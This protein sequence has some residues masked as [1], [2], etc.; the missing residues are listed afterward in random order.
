M[1]VEGAPL[2]KKILTNLVYMPL[3]TWGL[4]FTHCRWRGWKRKWKSVKVFNKDVKSQSDA[5]LQE[6]SNEI[7]YTLRNML[8]TKRNHNFHTVFQSYNCVR[9]KLRKCFMYPVQ[10]VENN[11]DWSCIDCFHSILLSGLTYNSISNQS[12]AV[13]DLV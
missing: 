12:P 13:H 3:N 11:I 8:N 7:C 10:Y 2:L 5:L 6:D 4:F 1:P 9:K